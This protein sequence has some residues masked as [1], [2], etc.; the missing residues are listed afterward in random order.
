MIM[1]K[2]LVI[3]PNN[4][5]F[6]NV[7]FGRVAEGGKAI[8]FYYPLIPGN[9]E[10]DPTMF[11]KLDVLDNKDDVPIDNSRQEEV[12]VMKMARKIEGLTGIFGLI[13]LVANNQNVQFT[14][15]FLTKVN[16]TAI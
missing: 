15:N 9:I 3:D 8:Y 6:R 2:F 10:Q 1:I 14:N 11:L 5:L 12:M 4:L 7:Y 13:R 16:L